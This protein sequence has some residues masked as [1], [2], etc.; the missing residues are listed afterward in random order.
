MSDTP[1]P[2]PMQARSSRAGG[3]PAGAGLSSLRRELVR[4]LTLISAVWV[5]AVFLVMAFGI[6]HEVDDLMDDALQE[7]AEV[8]YG[9]LVLH[10]RDLILD[11][12]STLPA[13]PHD[14]RLV[15]QILEHSSPRVLLR[16]HRAPAEPLVPVFRAGLGDSRD[17]WRVYALQL[18]QPGLFL[19]VAQPRF[20]RLESRYEVIALVGSSGLL[21]GVACAI[22]MRRRVMAVMRELQG[23]SQQIQRYDPMQPDTDMPPPT[24]QEFV[25][26]R[27][28][29]QDLGRRLA[30]RVQ[31]EQ[32]FAAHAA[33]AL[34]TPL[35]G[36]DAQLAMALREVDPAVRSRIERSR[37]AVGRLKRVV[38]A[39]LALFRSQADLDI[40]TI[41]LALLLAHLPVEHLQVRVDQDRPL[42]ADPNLVAAALANLLD[43]A[44]RYGASTCWIT[45]AEEEG[46]QVLVVRDDGPGLDPPKQALLQA[47]ADHPQGDGLEGL[48]IKLAALVARAHGGRLVLGEASPGA[49]GLS[50]LLV[51]GPATA[52]VQKS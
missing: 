52:G 18:P 14:E 27:E 42:R 6:R 16:S 28:A 46:R 8:L 51:L 26:V 19:V 30:R 29:V 5:L 15:W 35:A 17:H 43:N 38:A 49:G 39:L 3:G 7:A 44:V 32:A 48:G 31:S 13:P 24:R 22:W 36:M 12:R 23:L 47:G 4:T 41:D 25:Q 33:H 11:G 40:Q 1:P 9:T 37:E 20:E 2:P 50:V 10:E 45:V 21:V 34:R